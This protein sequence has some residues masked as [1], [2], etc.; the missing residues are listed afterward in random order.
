MPNLSNPTTKI[1]LSGFTDNIG[2]IE[3]NKMISTLRARACANYLINKGVDKDRI[4][5]KG[6]GFLNPSSHNHTAAGRQKN[7][8]VEFKVLKK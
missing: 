7:R 8:R 3:G 2:S 5:Y 1:Q 4:K 6:Y